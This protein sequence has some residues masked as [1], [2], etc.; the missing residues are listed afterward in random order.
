MQITDLISVT[1]SFIALGIAIYSLVINLHRQWVMKQIDVRMECQ[2]RFDSILDDMSNA[3]DDEV[4]IN[5]LYLRFWELQLVQFNCWMEGLLRDDTY[6]YWMS[7]RYREREVKEPVH[8]VTYPD[9][10]Q[11]AK[12]MLYDKNFITFMD[13]V[14]SGKPSEA[15]RFGKK[16]TRKA[17]KF[18]ID[19]FQEQFEET[20]KEF[21]RNVPG[22]Q[23]PTRLQT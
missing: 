21:R 11:H 16:L 18:Q 2:R 8:S 1:I 17:R 9:G 15:Y 13:L 23:T 4:H 22:A 5:S 7:R 10:W 19:A 20:K 3:P 12:K 6:M 14:V